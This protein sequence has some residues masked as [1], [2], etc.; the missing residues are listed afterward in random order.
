MSKIKWSLFLIGLLL[1]ACQ[2][3]TTKSS[4]TTNL[5]KAPTIDLTNKRILFLGNSITH[6][7]LYVSLLEYA[8]RKEYPNQKID[9]ISIGLG[10]ETVS[11][12][13]E[14]DHPYPRPCLSERI[15]RAITAVQ[16][17]LI[18]ATYGIND[19]IYHPPSAERLIAYQTGIQQLIQKA[20]TANSQLILLSP[21]PFDALPITKRLAAINAPEFSYKSPYE[22]YDEVLSEYSNW[23]NT[24]ENQVLK[25]IDWHTAINQDLI[26][27]R[28]TKPSFSYAKDGIHPN[29]A[30]HLLMAQ[31]FLKGVN[32]NAVNAHLTDYNQIQKDT[33]F[34][35]I[36]RARTNRSERWRNYIGYTRGKTVKAISPKSQLII[37]GG[38]SNMSGLGK[39][40]NLAD[41]KLSKNIAFINYGLTGNFKIHPDR[42]GPEYG[43]SEKLN[44]A[45]PYQHFTLL[46][47]SIGGASLLD[48]A[49][50]Y[51]K[52]K[53]EITGNAKF[54]NVY[55]QCFEK[56]DSLMKNE[57]VEPAAFLWMQ[58]ERDARIPEAGKDYYQNFKQLIESIR[59][60]LDKPNLPFIFGM[61]N[62]PAEKYAA[63]TTVRAAQRKIA[64]DL[65]NV[66][67]IE[68]DDLEK[69]KDNLHYNAAGQMELGHR[70]G[71]QLKVLLA[72]QQ[73]SNQLALL[74]AYEEKAST[75]DW[76]IEKLDTQA[77]IFQ[78]DG[79]E[80]VI[81]NGLVSRTFSISPNFATTSYKNLQTKEE[82]I[83]A[84]KPEAT[85]MI[86]SVTYPIGGLIGQKEMGYLLPEW[87]AEMKADSA[88]FGFTKFE[89][90]DLEER[91]KWKKTRWATTS[92]HQAKGKE[93]ICY[94]QHSL[95]NLKGITVKIHYEIYDNIPLISKWLTVE[96]KGTQQIKINHFTSEIIAHPEKNNFVDIP[97]KWD[98]PNL[99]LENDYA[100]SG[101]TYDES[102]QALTWEVD[103]AYTSQVNWER[104]MPC[105]LKSQPKIGP[106][107][108]LE[109]G[110][111]FE[112]FR[113]FILALDNG[114]RERNT[115]A[116]RKM[117]RT[118]APWA[119]ENPI[120]MHLTSTD[121][122][123][124]KSAIDQC[125]ETGYEMVI[126][127]FGSGL[128]MEDTSTA[129]I[130]K[131]KALADYAHSKNIQLGGYSLFS[132]RQID[133]E[134][135]VVDIKTGLPGGAKFG[136]HA[137]CGGSKWGLSYFQKLQTF[138]NQ[139]G[140]DILEHDGPYPGDFCASE[141]HPGHV[142]YYDSQWT[143]W[144]QTTDFYKWIRQAGIYTNIPDFYFLS[145]SNK[146]GIG[147]RE[148]NWSLPRAQQIILGRQ[149][150]YDGTWTKTPSMNWTFVPLTEYHGGG[151]D[152]TLEP[153]SEHLDSYAA[154]MTQ[155]YK[156]GVQA[157]YRGP[158]LYDTE[159][160]KNLVKSNIDHYKKYRDI[161]NA[162][163]I[164]LRRPDGRDWDGILHADPQLPIKGY[165]VLYNPLPYAIEREISLP[166]YYTGLKN[167]AV[168]SING[169][170]FQP[171]DLDR[172]Y[173][174]N[175]HVEI[176]ASGHVWVLI[177]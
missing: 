38:Q 99:Y 169:A 162:D 69:L 95:P 139:T 172:N 28:K 134:T 151:K 76:L 88:A 4:N 123:I 94:Y 6:N 148:V 145:G 12:L 110:K 89:V 100:F 150:I 5:T 113:T 137:P 27:K 56:V 141:N 142:D 9:L 67:I 168:I 41:T 117:Y 75:T 71:E 1:M 3:Y 77:A 143:Q 102:N 120:F 116:K 79:K 104:K 90:K 25:V 59:G 35:K 65:P 154:H 19:G 40:E 160:T 126:L 16:P 155:N 146:V 138:L 114:D 73:R 31:L 128:N 15:D 91:F 72:Q 156:S 86:D 68:T 26:E 112:S 23:L 7:G 64:K 111:S 153:L 158:R 14:S 46:K 175:L 152:A 127:S 130:Q 36:H 167:N 144:R 106:Q 92:Q 147:Y 83:R 85:I 50:N 34:Q 87:L 140:F 97:K 118:L 51:S 60:K 18:I 136:G 45:F 105:V 174:I 96:N 42:F 2:N 47:Y 115:L 39:K 132:S 157:C 66:F 171:Y 84:V 131:F 30:G 81:S 107:V 177:K 98:Y 58:G 173:Q 63:L 70:F 43:L 119:T 62:P 32:L 93:I 135:D 54:G 164:H 29:E 48:W 11:G 129:N 37:M 103:P 49:P 163:V 165:A 22:K 21:T 17:D 149:N 82:Y 8:L 166:L 161:L 122:V 55:A 80:L 61:V 170:A 124:V 13:T 44:E 176:P 57:V 10:S 133:D 108:Q 159:A 101:M 109:Q 78:K 24:L 74:P 121:P 125:V 52:E 53:A 20:K 33:F